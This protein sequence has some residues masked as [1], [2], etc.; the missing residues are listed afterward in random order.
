MSLVFQVEA[1]APFI[2]IDRC[3]GGPEVGAGVPLGPGAASGRPFATFVRSSSRF[4][5]SRFCRYCEGA[6]TLMRSFPCGGGVALG[7]G[8]AGGGG[9]AWG[10]ICLTTAG[11]GMKTRDVL[12]ATESS[13]ARRWTPSGLLERTVRISV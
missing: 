5:C 10:T 12:R 2:A 3:E 9:G 7:L 8:G 11:G 13:S 6:P 1:H 4:S